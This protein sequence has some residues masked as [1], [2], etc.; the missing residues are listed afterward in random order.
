MDINPSGRLGLISA[1][2][3]FVCFV[4]PS[5]AAMGAEGAAATGR[6]ESVEAFVAI[7]KQAKHR[8]RYWKK[9]APLRFDKVALK[10][11]QKQAHGANVGD[12]SR[13]IP[14]SIPNANAKPAIAPAA[15]TLCR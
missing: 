8:S 13:P 9:K 2:A 6:S 7:Q 15:D 1:M 11:A 4:A 3:L 12:G 14:P 10:S 5:Q